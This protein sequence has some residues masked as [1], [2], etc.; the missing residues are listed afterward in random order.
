[1]DIQLGRVYATSRKVNFVQVTLGEKGNMRSGKLYLRCFR[2][3]LVDNHKHLVF[4]TAGV[5]PPVQ[6]D[7]EVVIQRSA[8]SLWLWG[9]KS[10]YDRALEEFRRMTESQPSRVI[11]TVVE[12]NIP[13]TIVE[14]NHALCGSS[15][16]A[17]IAAFYRRHPRWRPCS[18]TAP[19]V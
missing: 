2:S 9:L 3:V 7:E 5:V 10:E 19:E 15:G 6:I 1:M 17:R 11:P 4:D 18:R 16:S 12:V 8:G 14:Q 13:P